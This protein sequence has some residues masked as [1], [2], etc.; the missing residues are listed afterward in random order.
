M[1]HTNIKIL[2][3]ASLL[4]ILLHISCDIEASSPTITNFNRSEYKA[5]NKNW[6]ISE[7]DR[8]VMYFGNDMG[9]LEFDGITWT[10]HK[11]P[12]NQTVRS[13]LAISNNT[14]YTGSYE[15][16]GVWNRDFD[17][18]LKYKSLSD[19]IQKKSI[20][21]NDIWKIW[22]IA[23][24][25]YFQSFG[26]IYVYN[27]KEIQELPDKNTLFLN[28][29]YQELWVQEMKG[30]IYKIDDNQYNKIEGS[31]IFS[32][33]DVRFILPYE[34]HRYLIGT[35]NKGLYIY[36]QEKFTQWKT[37]I[38][39]NDK[40]LNCG[41]LSHDG[42]Y[43]LGTIQDGLFVLTRDG[44]LVN[45]FNAASHLQNN[46]VLSIFEDDSNN[47]WTALDNGISCIHFF[48][49][50]DSY[51]DPTGLTGAVY[52][53]SFFDGKLFIGT[54]KGL[55]YYETNT[56][57]GDHKISQPQQVK[58]ILGQV[59]HLD[60]IDGM[61]YC[62]YN[63]GLAV[64]D[65]NL[66]LSFPY[67]IDTGVFSFEEWTGGD[68]LLAT[69]TALSKIN[70]HTKNITVFNQISEPIN[71]IVIDHLNNIWLEQMN[72]GVYKCRMNN[73]KT[74]IESYTYFGKDTYPDMPY[75][76]KLFKVGGRAALLGNNKAYTYND[77]NGKIE[78][79]KV[80]NNEI[81]RISDIK[82]IIPINTNNYWVISSNSLYKIAY[83]GSSTSVIDKIDISGNNMYLVYNYENVVILNDS[84][85]LICL[86]NG[87]L[88]YNN[89]GSNAKSSPLSLPYIKSFAVNN[90]NEKTVYKNPATL[91]EIAYK[92]NT[93][94][95]EFS[96]K[97]AFSRNVYFQYRL[98]GLEGWSAPQK[99][100]HITY[101]RLPKGDYTF[102]LKA[103]DKLGN[104]SEIISLNFTILPPWYE[105]IWAYIAYIITAII[106]LLVIWSIVLRRYR[107]LHLIKVRM[108]EAKRLKK[109]NEKLQNEVAEKNAELL[110]Q[111]SFIIQRNDLI[112]K[113]KDE[114]ESFFEK[115][116]NKALSPLVQKI[117]VLLNK[118]MDAE[119]D[120]KMFLIKFEEKHTGFFQRIKDIYPQLTANDLRLSACLRLNLDS[121]EIAALMN[122]S[123]RAVENSRYRIRKK[124]SIP[125]NE[126]LNE[127]FMKL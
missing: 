10:L 3:I 26:K 91:N 86:D 61:L 63:R 113:I 108:R 44:K 15:N 47:I 37:N 64:I 105:T 53:A 82:N 42:K 41:I 4:L 124:L 59:W 1:N 50:I 69:Y 32:D 66:K 9:L 68:I 33:T 76:F 94:N 24:R 87:F 100:N 45:H 104:Q 70:I 78:L 48:D 62:G 92:F 84:I 55:Y 5:A 88:L 125:Q 40:D 85:N 96:S 119:E 54:N 71:H 93:V 19:S 110:S 6:S 72:K 52:T 114:V 31:E 121:K 102:Q 89:N 56:L 67:S 20:K 106:V 14:I 39:L 7:D 38:D 29:I 81:E 11:M 43:Y 117:N 8:G 126:N 22:N 57:S 17:G 120:W 80:L 77:I 97:E 51:I 118:N 35:S 49:N 101:Q 98:V 115:Y 36:D 122:I 27:G 103:V 109:H 95:I 116:N 83:D 21:N 107:N 90:V 28:K 30:S 75:K 12:Y 73:D 34:G 25:I 65:K 60:V 111:T 123:V 2:S 18:Q 79:Y 16:F 13:V 112:I 58:G 46:T 99:A 127:F 23:N 74:E